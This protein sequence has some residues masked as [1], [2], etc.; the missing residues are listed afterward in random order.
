MDTNQVHIGHVV[1]FIKERD[2]GFIENE[3]GEIY[4]FF[5]DKTNQKKLKQAGLIPYVHNFISGDRVSF[6]LR[7]SQ[8]DE[9]KI[10]AYD[11]AFITNER[12]AILINNLQENGFLE[13]Y[14]KIFDSETIFVKDKSTYVYVPIAISAW[15]ENLEE[16]YQSRENALVRYKLNQVVRTDKLSA[17]LSDAKFVD[18]YYELMSHYDNQTTIQASITGKSKHG[19]HATLFDG[20]VKGFLAIPLNQIDSINQYNK[21]DIVDVRIKHKIQYGHRVVSLIL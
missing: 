12:R 17:T 2:F 13:G 20:K 11:V 15:E 8:R 10:E 1:R 16:V 4:F 18:E 5:R 7:L 19:Y 14:I 6:K 3:D 21:L 9:G